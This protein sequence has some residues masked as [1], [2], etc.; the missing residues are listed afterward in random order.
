MKPVRIRR[1]A[2]ELW[3]PRALWW[4]SALGLV[5]ALGGCGLTIKSPDLFQIQR[6]GNG[7]ELGLLVNDSGTISCNGSSPKPLADPLLLKARDL[8]SSLDQVA[9]L[10]LPVP[11]NSVFHYYVV[12]P[13]GSVSFPDTAA[14]HHP[15]LAQV[16]QFA[17]QAEQQACHL[18]G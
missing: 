13:Y 17:L 10:R 1:T 14:A 5:L 12:L 9:G 8:A 3:P 16:E 7:P 11:H 15:L 6:R 2:R 4:L 18:S